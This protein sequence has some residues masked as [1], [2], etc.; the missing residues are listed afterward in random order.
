MSRA[1]AGLA[2]ITVALLLLFAFRMGAEWGADYM[3]GYGSF[4]LSRG[5]L[6][7]RLNLLLLVLPA[8][9][10]LAWGFSL[11]TGERLAE[12][13]EGLTGAGRGWDAA[14]AIW[15]LLAT[16]AV[17]R[18]VLQGA[19]VTD[20]ENAYEFQA[21]LLETGRLFVPSLPEPVRAFLDNAAI[22]ND[23]RRYSVYFLG[24]S[25]WLAVFRRLALPNLAGPVA[26][27]ATALLTM[28]TARRLF[29]ARAA[30]LTAGLL[31]TS[32][33]LIL[34]GATHLSQPTTSLCTA[35]FLYALVR[36]HDEPARS[37]WWALGA[38][39]ISAA[40]LT[41]PQTAAGFF[42]VGCGGVA[43]AVWRRRLV[44]G[45]RS[46]WTGLAVGA[47]GLALFL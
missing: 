45:A 18:Y 38:A 1:W 31:A 5:E 3:V 26:T 25:A 23:G 24:H 2:W 15:L 16:W 13:F 8:G 30:A 4:T 7:L 28:A 19:E 11:L 21:R 6:A 14:L 42:L 9:L 34:L 33:F 36:L 20:D 22:V 37:R 47:A 46:I 32:P 27:A 17:R 40:V 29:G 10:A 44:P 39:G 12:R 35:A 43:L 41:R